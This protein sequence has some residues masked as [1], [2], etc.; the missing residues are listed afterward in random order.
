VVGAPIANR[1]HSYGKVLQKKGG[2]LSQSPSMVNLPMN[3]DGSAKSDG[4]LESDGHSPLK[5]GNV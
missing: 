3:K 4:N 5:D 2:G 1:S